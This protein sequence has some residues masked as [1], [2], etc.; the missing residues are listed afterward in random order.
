MR[1][2]MP[3]AFH[4]VGWCKLQGPPRTGVRGGPAGRGS[5]AVSGGTAP[6]GSLLLDL[7]PDE[8]VTAAQVTVGGR[9][10]DRLDADLALLGLL[11]QLHADDALLGGLELGRLH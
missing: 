3:P 1:S 5:G 4:F 10:E 11:R 6:T 7:Y 2:S 9:H 8:G